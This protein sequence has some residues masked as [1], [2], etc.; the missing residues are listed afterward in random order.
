MKKNH[1]VYFIAVLFLLSGTKVRA[2]DEDFNLDSDVSN[3]SEATPDEMSL[4]DE[5]MSAESTPGTTTNPPASDT[6]SAA[7]DEFSIDSQEATSQSAAP[8]TTQ[9]PAEDELLSDKADPLVSE[10]KKEE[11]KPQ[12]P[13]ATEVPPTEIAKP[14][15]EKP[16]ELPPEPVVPAQKPVVEAPP[17]KPKPTAKVMASDDPDLEREAKFHNIYEKYNQSPTSEE[18]WSKITSGKASRAY[19]VQK[20]DTLWDLSKT[21]FGDPNYWPKIWSLNK[22]SIYNPHEI[23]PKLAVQFFPGSLDQAPT[24][25]LKDKVEVQAVVAAN[26]QAAAA[27]KNLSEKEKA[28]ANVSDQPAPRT[29]IPVLKHLPPSFPKVAIQGAQKETGIDIEE[30]PPQLMNPLVPLST[31][32]VDSSLNSVGVVK[33]TEMGLESAYEFQYI[34]VELEGQPQKTYSVVKMLPGPKGVSSRV[35]QIEILGEIEVLDRV[36]NSDPYYRAVVKKS[37]TRVEVGGKLLPGSIPRVD[38][39]K[40]TPNMTGIA[41]IVGGQF[42]EGNDYFSAHTFIFLNKG[43]DQGIQ[44]GQTLPVYQNS[45]LRNKS[46]LIQTNEN[47]VGYMKVVHVNAESATGYVIDS[48]SD[49]RVGDFVGAKWAGSASANFNLN[50]SN[51]DSDEKLDEE[52]LDSNPVPDTNSKSE[53]P[54]SNPDDELAL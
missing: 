43:S 16:V 10:E 30:R 6:S 38:V 47:R 28:L 45:Q 36:N 20:G 12:E 32:L 2:Q 54:E 13:Q 19:E 11:V 53:V 41:D 52:N 51:L 31:Y 39:S 17:A 49:I 25:G 24:L 40:S 34:V 42:G 46:S 7:Q 3:A 4:P 8:E 48:N 26:E 5:P 14:E 1:L 23:N 37:L 21:L 22:N 27:G 33:E 18:E 35:H 9:E 44:V 50:N 15:P 29:I